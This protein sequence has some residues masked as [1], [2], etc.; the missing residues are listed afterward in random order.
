MQQVSGRAGRSKQSGKVLIQTYFPNQP[1]IQSLK[2]RDR[3]R[4]VEQSLLERKQFNV[5]PFSFLT[6]IIISGSSKTR[7]ESYSLD[8]AKTLILEDQISIFGPVEAPLFLLRGLYR[9]RL[10][11]K[12]KSRR[13]LNNFTRNLIKNCPIPSNLRLVIDVDPYTFV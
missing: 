13:K 5:P 11:L 6:A 2:K 9:Y 8:L 3:K 7:V 1:I 4:F 12:A 10:L